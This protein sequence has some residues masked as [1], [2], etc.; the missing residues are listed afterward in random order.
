[1]CHENASNI[2]L[3]EVTLI[4]AFSRIRHYR[5]NLKKQHVSMQAGSFDDVSK[6][7]SRKEKQ[8]V[9]GIEYTSILS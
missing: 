7:K 4:V 2:H 9:K 3:K 1:M 6:D 8:C 5:K